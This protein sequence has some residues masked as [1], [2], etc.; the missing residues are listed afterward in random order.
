MMSNPSHQSRETPT[1]K[2]L[3]DADVLLELFLN[4]KGTIDAAQTLIEMAQSHQIRL[5]VTDLCFT[6]IRFYLSQCQIQPGEGAIANL[7]NTFSQSILA[8][9]QQMIDAARASPLSDFESAI[10]V[11]CSRHSRLDAIVTLNTVAFQPSDY[12]IWSVD[13]LVIRQRLEKTIGQSE[14]LKSLDVDAQSS[15]PD[16]YCYMEP[17]S[18]YIDGEATHD[19]QHHIENLLSKQPNIR[20]LYLQ[21]LLLNRS[22]KLLPPPASSS[23]VEKI[24]NQIDQRSQALRRWSGIAVATVMITIAGVWQVLERYP[25]AMPVAITPSPMLQSGRSLP[26]QPLAPSVDRPIDP[27]S[28]MSKSEK[29]AIARDQAAPV[30]MGTAPESLVLAI[31]QP[32]FDSSRTDNPADDPS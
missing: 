9:N 7:E 12:P 17:L 28:V 23:T 14:P 4:R 6:K 11:A 25:K 5:Y 24:L 19:E 2:I 29:Q 1:M 15:D 30:E 22:I 32:L 26:E 3:A 16:F 8:I 13:E 31:D 18:L 20:R 10:E 27:L 21:L